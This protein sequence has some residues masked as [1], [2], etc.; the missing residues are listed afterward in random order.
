M[1]LNAFHLGGPLVGENMTGK[2]N[3]S[4]RKAISVLRSSQVVMCAR[5]MVVITNEI[6]NNLT[7]P[8]LLPPCHLQDFGTDIGGSR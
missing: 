5:S 2:V 3:Y 4:T 6:A 8:S 1:H 7:Y